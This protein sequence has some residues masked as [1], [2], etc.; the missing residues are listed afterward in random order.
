MESFLSAHELSVLMLI[1]QAA[2]HADLDH[3]EVERLISRRLVE[4]PTGASGAPELKVA[5]NGSAVL[6]RIFAFNARSGR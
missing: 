5:N 6:T 3:R 1:E 2:W 4:Q